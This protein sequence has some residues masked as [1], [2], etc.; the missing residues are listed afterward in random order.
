[1]LD[2]PFGTKIRKAVVREKH[3]KLKNTY[4]VEVLVGKHKG[5][6]FNIFESHIQVI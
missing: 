4:R 5:T 3:P 2:M 1:M 6:I